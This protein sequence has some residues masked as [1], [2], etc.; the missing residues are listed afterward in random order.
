MLPIPARSMRTYMADP[1]NKE[2]D[3]ERACRRREDKFKIPAN[4]CA[5]CLFILLLQL[6]EP[7]VYVA[8]RIASPG[9]SHIAMPIVAIAIE[10][11]PKV[12]P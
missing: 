11:V 8:V 2:L 3:K 1:M 5:R 7:G 10:P 4:K 6:H 12:G 9:P